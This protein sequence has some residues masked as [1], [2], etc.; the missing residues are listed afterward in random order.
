MGVPASE[1]LMMLLALLGAGIVT[2]VLA[3]AHY[4]RGVV[5]VAVLRIWAIPTIAGVVLGGTLA[6]DAPAWLFKIV[7]VVIATLLSIKLLFG[8]A[9]WKLGD[10]LP[11][12][13]L[14]RAYGF[15]IGSASALMG[16]GGGALSNLVMSLY[17]RPIHQ[18]VATSSGLGII[19]SIPGVIA[20]AVGGWSKMGMLP[21]L[22]IGFVSLIGVALMI[23]T[24]ILAA[25]WGVRI[26]HALPQRKL[27]IIFGLYL[28]LVAGRFFATLLS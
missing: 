9:S 1:L 24:T 15:V 22:S 25:P 14:M 20:Y 28:A 2:G 13:G 16:V 19:I 3:G 6:A 26:A 17:R 8:R 11:G 12:K 5:D 23:P 7:F 21:P 27:E 18:A 4:A 10:N